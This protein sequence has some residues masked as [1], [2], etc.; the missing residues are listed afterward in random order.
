MPFQDYEAEKET[1]SASER[2][3]KSE[4]MHFTKKGLKRIEISHLVGSWILHKFK[5]ADPVLINK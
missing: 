1:Y 4:F 3:S 5:N 2:E